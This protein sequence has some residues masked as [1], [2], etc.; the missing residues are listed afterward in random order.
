M[1][2]IAFKDFKA[3]KSRAAMCIIGVMVCVL[4]IGT[5][6]NVLYEMEAGLKGDLGT[7]NGKLYFEK[8]GTG[9]PPYG[10][11]LSESLGNE[12]QN[13]SEINPYKSTS[14][15][16]APLEGSSTESGSSIM[17]VGLTPGREQAFIQNA[18][19]K[20]KNTL[21]D[22][23]ENAV[24]L[25][26][27]SALQYNA[28]VGE[29]IIINEN[30]FRVIGIMERVGT[31]W[32]LTIDYSLIMSLSHAQNVSNMPG[33]ISTVIIIPNSQYTLDH[34]ENSL[35]NDYPKY[36]I[37]SEKDTQK[38]I[39]KNL[40]QIQIFMNMISAFIFIVSIVFIMN[41]MMM[42][43]KEKTK[44]IGT[45]RAIGTKKRSIIALIIYESLIMSVIG[46]VIGIILIS[47]T[48]NLMGLL[49]GYTEI[50]FLEFYLPLPVI[51]QLAVIIFVI[52]TFSG[53][54]PAYLANRISPIEAL[55]YE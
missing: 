14:A 7:V 4:L 53:L 29:T 51:I 12:V 19:V 6:N 23:V 1:L 10:S 49:M 21:L 43:V 47:P 28:S 41:V 3:K 32:P 16:F 2:D 8:N 46:G 37:Y 22:E 30:Q 31:G 36:S 55:R 38:T 45:M 35:Q 13:R 52:G 9:Y 34:A 15:L 48:Y 42:T 18:T 27:E 50:N 25:G 44:E 24:I 17:I 26:S 11:V 33:L 40:S 54:L 39:E 20:G 5:V